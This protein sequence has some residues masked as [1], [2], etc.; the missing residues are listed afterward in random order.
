MEQSYGVY[1]KEG[2]NKDRGGKY[3]CRKAA[4]YDNCVKYKLFT[5][6]GDCE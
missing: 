6:I 1:A 3:I 5:K 2:K 4:S